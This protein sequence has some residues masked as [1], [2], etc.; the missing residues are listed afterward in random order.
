ML[1]GSVLLVLAALL[2][3]PFVMRQEGA[4]TPAPGDARALIILSPHNEQIR[5]EFGAAF[6]RWHQERFGEP[7]RVV[8]SVPGGTSEIR[9]ML[10]SQARAALRDDRPLGGNADLLFGGGSF[11]FAELARPIEV[12]VEGS[13]RGGRVLAPM[14]FDASFLREVYGDENRI[15]DDLLHD[16]ELRWFGTALSGFGIVYNQDLLGRLGV[17][18]P[19]RWADLTD[20]RLVGSVALVNPAQSSSITTAFEAI[21][22]RRGWDEGWRTLRRIAANAR[23]FSA[24]SAKVPLDVAAGEAAAGICIDFYGRFESQAILEAGGGARVGY[25][26]PAGE[27]RLDADPIALLTGA[28]SP[29]LARRFVEFVLSV[30]GQSLWQFSPAASAERRA[31][32]GSAA[33]SKE[34]PGPPEGSARASMQALAEGAP[35]GPLRYELRR[36]PIRRSMY[37]T[38]ELFDRFVDQ[39]DPWAIATGVAEADRNVRAFIVP[40]FAAMAIEEHRLLRQAWL[41]ITA[42]PAYPQERG[43]M[44]P[45][46][47]VDDPVLRRMLEHFDALPAVPSPGGGSVSLAPGPDLSAR[48]A[49][50]R[51]GWLREGWNA[52]GLW[53]PEASPA[54]ELR[55]DLRR[56]FEAEY[57]A[58]LTLAAP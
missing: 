47:E 32:A 50:V 13:P 37:H 3:M 18:T 53:P 2:L 19:R 35:S 48:L 6:E 33:G 23:S 30:E 42:H 28:P 27:T 21:L 54:D 43:G 12:E 56:S 36:L 45:A 51:G 5:Q 52:E 31:A 8:W 26:D 58:V 16:P 4:E 7:V 39:V 20:P 17:P 11:E 49:T 9:R 41:A 38:P 14:E 10:Q 40:I 24:S 34:R 57:R 25:I 55:R 46:E 1:R 22:L 15:G 44:V 29:D